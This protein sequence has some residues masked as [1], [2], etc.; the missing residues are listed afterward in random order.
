MRFKVF[1]QL[2]KNFFENVFL[3]FFSA[4][5]LSQAIFIVLH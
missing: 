5:E 3:N 2:P 4:E 1:F